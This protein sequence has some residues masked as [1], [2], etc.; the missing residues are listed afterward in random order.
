MAAKIKL[1]VKYVKSDKRIV[2]KCDTVK[3]KLRISY[4]DK[5]MVLINIQNTIWNNK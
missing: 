4:T 1:V 3:C 5:F 2:S